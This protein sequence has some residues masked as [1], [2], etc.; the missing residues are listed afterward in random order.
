MPSKTFI[1][2]TKEYSRQILIHI[3]GSLN[4]VFTLKI[5]EF[6]VYLLLKAYILIMLPIHNR[7]LFVIFCFILP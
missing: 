1:M 3:F 7:P 2:L 4:F 5:I 6:N